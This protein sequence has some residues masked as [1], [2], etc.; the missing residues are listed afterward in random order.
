MTHRLVRVAFGALLLAC[1][2][3]IFGC[4]AVVRGHPRGHTLHRVEPVSG[5]E[6]ELYVPSSYFPDKAWPVIVTC[7][8]TPPFDSAKLQIREWTDLAEE[9]GLIVVAPVLRG[10]SA[11]GDARPKTVARQIELQRSDELT[12]L[13]ALNHVKAGYHVDESRIFL[14]GWSAGSYA[15]LWTGLSHPEIFRALAVRQGNFNARFFEPIE[16]KINR[17]QPVVVFYGQIDLLRPQAEA[18]IRWLKEHGMTVFSD[19]ITGPHRRAPEVAY[20]YFVGIVESCPW[21]VLRWEPGW[22][23]N[24]L[25]ARFYAKADPAIHD[26]QWNF[27]D[28]QTATGLTIDHKYVAGGSYKITVR[29]VAGRKSHIERTMEIAIAPA[30]AKEA[31]APSSSRPAADIK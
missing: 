29:A 24:P 11:R 7:H 1:L 18:C 6:Y 17:Q 12:I 9:K 13:A 26:V 20:K 5:Q 8:G 22:A 25:G 19:E 30:L 23:G 15:V 28:G 27:G 3:G 31:P 14:T 10:T 16:A 4:P 21:L 2:P